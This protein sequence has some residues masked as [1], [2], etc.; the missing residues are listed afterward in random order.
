MTV[1]MIT[2]FHGGGGARRP[3]GGDGARAHRVRGLTAGGAG[4]AAVMERLDLEVPTAYRLGA[5]LSA[6]GLA[7]RPQVDEGAMVDAVVR[8]LGAGSPAGPDRAPGTAP[9][10]GGW[11]LL[12]RAASGDVSLRPVSD[13]GRALRRGRR[14]RLGRRG[15]GRRR[16]GRRAD[17]FRSRSRGPARVRRGEL[18]L[19]AL[20]ARARPPRA[21]RG[22]RT[23]PCQ[24]GRRAGRGL[25]ARRRQPQ[26]ARRRVPG[27]R[28]AHGLGQIHPHPAH[29]RPSPP[30][31]RARAPRRARPRGQARRG[32]GQGARGR[33]VPVPRV[34]AVRVER[35]RGRRLR[36]AQPGA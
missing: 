28:R 25:G 17:P 18:Q 22:R 35:V 8:A 13:A 20:G 14:R 19:R 12:R 11:G 32:R 34:P 1:V 27:R 15:G 21:P 10:A 24:V 5:A 3:R 26:R 29:E 31:A 36:P 2:P 4:D 9:R 7:V 33:G 6:C 23:P 16:L 30:A